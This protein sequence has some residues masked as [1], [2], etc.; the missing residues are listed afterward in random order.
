M[1]ELYFKTKGLTVGYN[2]K[3]LIRD[4][5][6][7]VERGEILTL[8]GPNGSGKSTILKSVTRQLKTIAGTVY[9]GEKDVVF[10]FRRGGCGYVGA[11][12]P[13]GWRIFEYDDNGKLYET[14][15][16]FGEN[17]VIVK[18]E[19]SIN[20]DVTKHDIYGGIKDNADFCSNLIVEPIVYIPEGVGN[21]NPVYRRTIS[22]YDASYAATLMELL[23][24]KK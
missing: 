3:P 5:E 23:N 22:R 18:D 6:F 8:I 16:R 7:G 20:S 2:G 9:L 1:G 14:I 11:F 13:K 24:D 21:P 17:E 4:I 19:T 15:H 12:R 10:L